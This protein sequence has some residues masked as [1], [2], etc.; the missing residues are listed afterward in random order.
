MPRPLCRNGKSCQTLSSCYQ[1]PMSTMNISLPD[2]LKAWADAQVKARSFT[3]LSEFV[4]DVLR[5][6]RQEI[7]V[8]RSQIFDGMNSGP[9]SPADDVQHRLEARLKASG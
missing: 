5:R 2:D 3:S 9:P 8:L 7:E 1:H 4:R 6:E